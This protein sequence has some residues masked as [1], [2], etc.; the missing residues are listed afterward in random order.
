M[1]TSQSSDE[2]YE[3]LNEFPFYSYPQGQRYIKISVFDI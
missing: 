3:A 2:K 1:N